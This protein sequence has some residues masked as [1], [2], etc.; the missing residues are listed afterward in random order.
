[1]PRNLYDD[2]IQDVFSIDDLQSLKENGYMNVL[3]HQDD[4]VMIEA[5]KAF[6]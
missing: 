2:N 5:G 6:L 4:Y 1:M 3:A